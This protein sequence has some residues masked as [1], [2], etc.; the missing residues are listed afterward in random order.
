MSIEIIN[1]VFDGP[2]LLK[3]WDPLNFP[4]IYAVLMKP[5]PKNEPE[6]YQLLY[7]CESSEFSKLESI[8]D[9]PKYESWFKE[10]GFKSNIYIS[11]HVMPN[12]TFED[13][14]LLKNVIT[15]MYEPICN[16]QSNISEE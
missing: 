10:A 11:A 3:E 13:R 9:H 6:S 16:S 5:D 14:K 12:S 4:A 7:I 8:L 2:H 1:R 15:G